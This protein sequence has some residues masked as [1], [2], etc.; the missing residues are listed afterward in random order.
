MMNNRV[1][2]RLPYQWAEAN[3]HLLWSSI[4][5]NG[6]Y[7][8][9]EQREAGFGLIILSI[10]L[11]MFMSALDGTI[12]NIALP[13]I[14]ESFHLSSSTVSWVATGVPA[15]HGRRRAGLWEDLGDMIGFKRVFLGVLS[16]SPSVPLTCGSV[17]LGFPRSSDPG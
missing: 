3:S 5:M 10:P 9:Q 15:R 8:Y 7:R 4:S 16:S 1:L 17:V 12:V 11:A 14:S 13:T 6:N 2:F